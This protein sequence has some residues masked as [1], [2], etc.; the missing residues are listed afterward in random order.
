MLNFYFKTYK[1]Q[2]ILIIG[3]WIGL[4]VSSIIISFTLINN[5]T[6]NTVV[7]YNAEYNTY[8]YTTSYVEGNFMATTSEFYW[9]FK[10]L[11][12]NTII[13][14]GLLAIIAIFT[15]YVTTKTRWISDQL[16]V[17][18]NEQTCNL[19]T[20]ITFPLLTNAIL[21]LIF[22]TAVKNA[23]GAASIYTPSLVFL[24]VTVALLAFTRYKLITNYSALKYSDNNQQ[25]IITIVL[26]IMF[27]V[28]SLTLNLLRVGIIPLIASIVSIIWLILNIRKTVK[29]TVG[30]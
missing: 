4:M 10:L 22:M 23:L 29:N 25:L 18:K 20:L 2:M 1:L 6:I 19:V 3:L 8:S 28:I 7:S 24:L 9:F 30:I 14:Y 26:V 16:I 15:F 12:F 27:T 13:K 21:S 5:D 11:T 17:G